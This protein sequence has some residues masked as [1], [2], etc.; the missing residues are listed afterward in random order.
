MA[1]SGSHVE[2]GVTVVVLDGVEGIWREF[3]DE[4]VDVWEISVAT[5]EEEVLLVA[6]GGFKMVGHGVCQ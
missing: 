6:F 5:A 1:V 2:D 3:R 4:E